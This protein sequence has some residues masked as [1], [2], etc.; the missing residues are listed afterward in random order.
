[1][2]ESKEDWEL[3]YWLSMEGVSQGGINCFRKLKWVHHLHPPSWKDAAS[4]YN[5]VKMMPGPP[6]W[7]S[8][9][10][11][12]KEAPNEPQTLYWHDPMECVHFLFQNPDF[13]GGIAYAPS[14][15]YCLDGTRVY[16]EM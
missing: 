2:Y 3:C 12:L 14:W 16:S 6:S 13:D 15:V 7:R 5:W 1:P 9:T 8:N 11:I 4:M 10:I